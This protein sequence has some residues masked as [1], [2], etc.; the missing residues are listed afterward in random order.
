MADAW[1]W[2][3][4]SG[5]DFYAT[6]GWGFEALGAFATRLHIEDNP[7]DSATLIE[8]LMSWVGALSL[9][10]ALFLSRRLDPAGILLVGS[11]PCMKL[12][13]T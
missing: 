1:R 2:D 5:R 6:Y 13:L 12:P 9:G 4:I 11:L 10:L 7:F 3:R 8:L